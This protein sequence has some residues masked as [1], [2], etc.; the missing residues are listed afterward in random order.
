MSRRNA[1]EWNHQE[2]A[3]PWLDRCVGFRGG[4]T[5]TPVAHAD[6]WGDIAGAIYGSVILPQLIQIGAGDDDEE[7]YDEG[8]TDADTQNSMSTSQPKSWPAVTLPQG[9]VDYR[10]QVAAITDHPFAHFADNQDVNQQFQE[11]LC[12]SDDDHYAF[13]WPDQSYTSPYQ[14]G[15]WLWDG[16]ADQRSSIKDPEDDPG[17]I[18]KDCLISADGGDEFPFYGL[19]VSVGGH[20]G[21]SM[22]LVNKYTNDYV[23]LFYKLDF[24]NQPHKAA[25]GFNVEDPTEEERLSWWQNPKYSIDLDFWTDYTGNQEDIALLR[26]Y[27]EG[28]VFD[29]NPIAR[30]MCQFLANYYY[31][32]QVNQTY[33]INFAGLYP[34]FFRHADHNVQNNPYL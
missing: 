18:Y 17:V 27:A 4:V 32:H 2:E 21:M 12:T 8:T 11:F 15:V 5:S 31:P 24:G 14:D 10:E 1:Y 16:D 6:G 34:E 30:F 23:V 9:Y 25:D 13:G 20:A 22:V 19:G 29:D 33:D 26:Q 7:T 28:R 3:L